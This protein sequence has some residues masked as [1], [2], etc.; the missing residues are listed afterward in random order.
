MEITAI[1]EDAARATCP[2]ARAGGYDAEDS[3]GGVW[4]LRRDTLACGRF[5]GL[6]RGDC[7]DGSGGAVSK[8]FELVKELRFERAG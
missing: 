5:V 6:G 7:A 3:G 4:S 8:H 2:V 1:D